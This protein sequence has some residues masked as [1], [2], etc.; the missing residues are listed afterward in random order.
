MKWNNAITELPQFK[1][2]M[3]RVSQIECLLL[4]VQFASDQLDVTVMEG[5]IGGI[6][7]LAG[8]AYRDL[9]RVQET[10]SESRGGQA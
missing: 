7:S 1:A 8:S 6:R 10:E 2:A 3:Q 5:A 9:E 4:A